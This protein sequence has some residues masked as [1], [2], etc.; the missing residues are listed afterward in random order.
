MQKFMVLFYSVL[1]FLVAA[2]L[3]TWNLTLES[4]GFEEISCSMSAMLSP[5][6][7]L[8]DENKNLCPALYYVILRP[9]ALMS[10][11]H[12]GIMRL[13]SILF[14]SLAPVLVYFLGRRL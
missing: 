5:L 8:H 10:D 2:G 13:P 6:Q 3:R 14:G 11:G 1:M 9:F 4:P 7:Y 12:L